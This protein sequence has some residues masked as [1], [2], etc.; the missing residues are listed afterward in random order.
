MPDPVTHNS[1]IYPDDFELIEQ[2]FMKLCR[3]ADVDLQSTT[4]LILAVRTFAEFQKGHC[5]SEQLLRSVAIS[6]EFREAIVEYG[7]TH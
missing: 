6:H 5:T 7:A 4:A 1:V 3:A 2:T